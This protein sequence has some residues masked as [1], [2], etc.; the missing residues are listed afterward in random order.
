MTAQK[1]Q[2]H[3]D[4]V[5]EYNIFFDGRTDKARWP[6]AHS[7]TFN[8]IQKIG[9]TEIAKYH[10][11]VIRGSDKPWRAQTKR[12]A[13]RIVAKAQLCLEANRNEAG[14]R[15]NLEH[16]ILARLTIEVA[17]RGCRARLWRSELE[18]TRDPKDKFSKSLEERQKKRKPCSC[19]G[20]RGG[21]DEFKEGINQLF[22]DRAEET[23]I[24]EEGL[25][26]AMQKK[27]KPD[28]IYGLRK[29][30]R[31]K[32]L[33]CET[34][35]KRAVESIRS[36]PFRPG[37]ESIVFPFLVLE[38][39]SE[40]SRDGFG[41]IEAQTAFTIRQ[42][43][44]LQEDLRR[45]TRKD[46]KWESGPLVW[47]LANKGALWRV[48][49]AHIEHK[50]G[51]QY[52]RIVDLWKGRLTLF[53][54]ALQLLLIVDYIFDWARDTYREA[55]ISELRNLAE[56]DRPSLGNDS[57]ILSLEGSSFSPEHPQTRG[58]GD[59]EEEGPTNPDELSRAI[60]QDPLKSF[61]S[62][63]GVL[64][65]ASYIRSRFVALHI[66]QDNLSVLM[67]S[68]KPPEKV[69]KTAESILRH[70]RDM[71]R[72]SRQALDT[73][74]L[75]WTGK[76]RENMSLDSPDG[77]FLVTTTVSAY[78][79]PDWE[80]TRE[81]YYVAVSAGAVD[82]LFQHANLKG[83]EPW[84]PS[85]IPWVEDDIF[86]STF[87]A[88]LAMAVKDNLIAAISRTN[89]S[90][91]LFIDETET[92]SN[93]GV[94]RGKSRMVSAEQ[95]TDSTKYRLHTAIMP[96]SRT[97][98]RGVVS[99]IRDIYKIGRH[100][101]VSSIIRQ[102]SRLDQQKLPDESAIESI[103]PGLDP[104]ATLTDQE[105]NIIFVTSTN[106][107]AGYSELCLFLIDA[108]RMDSLFGQDTPGQPSIA[109]KFQAMRMDPK[110]GLADGWRGIE[111]QKHDPNFLDS[112]KRF[113]SHLRELENFKTYME[114]KFV[115]QPVPAKF[116]KSK[117]YSE[118]GVSTTNPQPYLAILEF[119]DMVAGRGS[120]NSPITSVTDQ[121]PSHLHDE[122]RG[123]NIPKN[124][125]SATSSMPL[126][127]ASTR[128]QPL[129][130]QEGV[131][132]CHIDKPSKLLI[133]NSK[134]RKGKSVNM[135]SKN[136]ENHGNGPL[137]EQGK[138]TQGN[139]RPG[140]SRPG[141]GKQ[142]RGNGISSFSSRS[143][144]VVFRD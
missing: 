92:K 141:K 40:K 142:H 105:Q 82:Q 90:T 134:S 59:N 57:N 73:L 137:N 97:Y 94:G 133:S 15:L 65:D 126:A 117:K 14:W 36:T 58:S 24:Q 81:L 119:R 43:L 27:E 12:R 25:Q 37:G 20:G 116:W 98:L 16:E 118:W 53:S 1:K 45:A 87:Q 72:V 103:W 108:S 113:L 143:K 89:V 8:D 136:L 34:K 44:K 100:D 144:V 52:Y 106:P 51:V 135:A 120:P 77:V 138:G 33:L 111:V 131:P 67:A 38:A 101:L 7:K 26:A 2:A 64:R 115:E 28:R 66:T 68:M 79:S 95:T 56:N 93:D 75:R 78:L 70:L 48:A 9:R 127:P 130:R 3:R 41:D 18:V 69:Q 140:N 112:R 71:W 63:Y 46:S 55:I 19:P 85:D 129:G 23:I 61:D 17:C 121:Q 123:R 122:R 31:L 22:D 125:A 86:D 84:C 54:G 124:G 62:T 99:L 104:S 110:L 32:R 109:C 114:A 107:N 11:S 102:S 88:Y 29:T 21:L 6:S 60:I 5:S 13:E 91:K 128:N 139:S 49:A 4:L 50:N 10:E 96:G 30:S 83:K 80:Q 35:D 39:K 74:E 42:L 47:F 132:E 76:N